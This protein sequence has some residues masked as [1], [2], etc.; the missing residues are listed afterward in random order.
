MNRCKW[1]FLVLTLTVLGMAWA[2]ERNDL[3]CFDHP[4]LP[5]YGFLARKG[6]PGPATVRMK[7]SAD[8][9][10]YSAAWLGDQALR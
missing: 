1:C 3:S 8:G 9:P 5:G 2:K 7:V 10:F 4:V 6:Q